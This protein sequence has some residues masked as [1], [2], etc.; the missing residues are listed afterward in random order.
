MR[1]GL[2]LY[3]NCLPAGLFGAMDLLHAANLRAGKTLFEPVFVAARAGKVDC[4]HGQQL[5]AAMA[6]GEADV[7]AVLV[8]G[9][10]GQSLGQAA[11][12]LDANAGLIAALAALPRRVQLWAYCTGVCL[13]AGT[14]RLDRQAATITWWLAEFA[15]T[16][17]PNVRWQFERTLAFNERTASA[18]GVNGYLPIIQ[19]LIESRLG[20]EAYRELTRLMVLPRPEEST[21]LAFHMLDLIEQQ[22]GMLRKLHL[23]VEQVAASEATLAHVAALLHTTERTLARK[24]LAASGMPAA[25]YIRRI[26]LK[27]VSERLIYTKASATAISIELG[28]SSDSGM[29]RMF[30]ELTNLT[31]AQYRVNYSR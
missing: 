7:A 20:K 9:F 21:H 18:S 28:F 2:L 8:P 11:R 23:A 22:D 10:W 29:R 19:A 1:I 30:K 15:V 31:P 26:K 24:V 13:A 4:A 12:T 14:G 17:F 6:L 16:T 5:H 3:P 27:Q 25:A